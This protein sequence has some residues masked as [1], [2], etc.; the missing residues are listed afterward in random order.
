MLFTMLSMMWVWRLGSRCVLARAWW[1]LNNKLF[2]RAVFCAQNYI[3]CDYVSLYGIVLCL[4]PVLW[5][6]GILP[7]PIMVIIIRRLPDIIK[8]RTRDRESDDDPLAWADTV[9]ECSAARVAARLESSIWTSIL[10][11]SHCCY[12]TES[13]ATAVLSYSLDRKLL[14]LYWQSL[15]LILTSCF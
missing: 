6:I 10:S 13:A 1:A 11:E 7:V 14:I 3:W 9:P 4:V 2:I 5:L 15:Q 8:T 12:C